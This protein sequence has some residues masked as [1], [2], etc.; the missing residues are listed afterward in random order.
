MIDTSVDRAPDHEA[1][2]FPD[3]NRVDGLFVGS[4][5]VSD[6]LS[7]RP[8][9]Y[10]SQTASRPRVS[11]IVLSFEN[12]RFLRSTLLSV[13]R[14][15][16]ESIEIVVG[17]DGSRD[18]SPQVIREWIRGEPR[19]VLAILWRQNGGIVRNYNGALRWSRGDF[20]AHIGSDD[21]NV[22]SRVQAQCLA[23][24]QSSAAM[25]ISGMDVIDA[26]GR[27]LRRVDPRPAQ[28]DLDSVLARGGVAVTS[29]TMT[30][31]RR[32]IDDFGMLPQDLANEDEALAFRA[33]LSGGI[34][35]LPMSL[36]QYRIH[37]GSVTARNRQFSWA[38]YLRWLERN[39][40]FQ[41]ANKRHWQMSLEK[42]EAS[43]A[44][45]AEADRQLMVLESRF[46]LLRS[47]GQFGLLRRTARLLRAAEGRTMVR[48]F[49]D[50][51]LRALKLEGLLIR[52][53]IMGVRPEVRE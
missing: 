11:F 50:Q 26:E 1:L 36:V 13:S 18:P 34:E 39:L 43:P 2:D 7:N 48:G 33:L 41:L 20:I 12:A 51:A 42:I 38:G 53:R 31:R 19:P 47:T 22:A 28:Q 6:L 17:D 44:R 3:L 49:V 4:D 32:L 14:Q 15:S 37:S 52:A 29:P 8:A 23:L 40:P 9:A 10:W 24:E 25:C 5:A 35:V 46:T 30:Y 16:Y 45:K 27:T 21:I